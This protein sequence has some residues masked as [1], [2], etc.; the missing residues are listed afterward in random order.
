MGIKRNFT[1]QEKFTAALAIIK[2]EKSAVEV[3]RELNCHPSS[4]S[5][6]KD[7]LEAHGS[8][9]FDKAKEDTVKDQKIAT[10]ERL[11]GKLVSQNGFLERV[12][13]R[14]TGA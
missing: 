5:Y 14:S 4:I 9:T 1:S 3:G 12:L 11:V 2:G 6:W 8:V 7:D 13:E 10:L